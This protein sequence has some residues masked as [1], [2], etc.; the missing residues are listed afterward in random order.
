MCPLLNFSLSSRKLDSLPKSRP[1]GF[2]INDIFERVSFRFMK[3]LNKRAV[4]SPSLLTVAE[5]SQRL[6]SF[7]TLA[8][9]GQLLI[10][11]NM[12]SSAV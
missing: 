7:S 10:C 12:I 8:I 4:C 3:Y 6:C 9:A 5:I 11:D 1:S 2:N